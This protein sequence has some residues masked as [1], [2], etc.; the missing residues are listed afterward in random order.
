MNIRAANLTDLPAIVQLHDTAFGT[1]FEG[2]LVTELHQADLAPISLVATQPDKMTQAGK[3]LGHVLF[4]PLMVEVDQRAVKAL[5][6][7]P[8]AVDPI[9]QKQGIGTALIKAGL[10][11]AAQHDWQAVIVLGE[12]HFYQRFGFSA[13]LAAGFE[14]A[15]A[16]PYL[17]A[18]E[19]S[20]RSLSGQKGRIIY[21]E[22]F[23]NL[24]P[25]T[26]LPIT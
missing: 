25:E 10:V 9:S 18:L 7:A 3:I 24:D 22:P 8:V 23:W 21:A 6:L 12:P 17:M 20:P 1:V 19:L 13:A 15:F 14:S 11:A 5:A 4:S 2:R 16:S 26:P